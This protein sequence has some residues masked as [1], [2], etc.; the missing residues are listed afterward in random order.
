MKEVT[1]DERRIAARIK[2]VNEH[3]SA[4]NNHDLDR[5]MATLI[6]YPD[7]KLNDEEFGGGD[8]VRAFYAE[9]FRGFPDLHFDQTRRYVSDEAI[10]L[11]VTMTGTQTN[12]YRKIP[13][14]GR[15]MQ[16]P[17]CTI[18]LFD[19]NDRITG[20]RIYIDVALVLR[21]LGVLPPQ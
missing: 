13:A 2:L 7:Y 4:E 19:G 3:V 17:H 9:L 16:V 10:I 12:E 5:T 15:R 14:T 8:S 21:Q 1:I 18:F 20:E 6:E 11:E